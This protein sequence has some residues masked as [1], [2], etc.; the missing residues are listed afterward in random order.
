MIAGEFFITPH[1]VRQFQIRI[2][3]WMTY[4]QAL[5]A[6][7]RGLGSAGEVHSTMNGKARYVRVNGDWQ[8]RAVIGE[9]QARPAVITILRS[10]K[11]R[12]RQDSITGTQSGNAPK[13][14]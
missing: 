4:E 1:A 9:G 13:V 5:G 14:V 3:P 7:I 8:F 2:A 6:I 12:K 10:G 11:G